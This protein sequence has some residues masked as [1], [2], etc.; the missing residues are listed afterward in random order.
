MQ[1]KECPVQGLG[2]LG[3]S[4]DIWRFLKNISLLGRFFPL[5]DKYLLAAN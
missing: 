3:A 5:F 1:L 4:R 2:E